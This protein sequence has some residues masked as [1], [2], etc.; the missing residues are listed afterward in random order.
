MQTAH[1]RALALAF[2]LFTL[3]THAVIIADSVNEFSSTQGTHNWFYGFYNQT[4]DASPGYSAADFILFDTF[5]GQAWRASDAQVGA[6]NN[7]F[8]QTNP[9][10][11]HPSGLGPQPQNAVIWAM[12]RY[13]SEAAGPIDIL[14]DLRKVNVTNPRGNG[15]SGRIFVDGVQIYNEVVF[16]TD[17]LAQVQLLTVDVALGSTIDFA[18]DPTGS[19]N[20]DGSG[21]SSA[22]ADGSRLSAVIREAVALPIPSSLALLGL[23]LGLIGMRTH[24]AS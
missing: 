19:G 2:S 21:V 20:A 12:R 11:G 9:I 3:P 13:V 10:G 4:A 17:D 24:R 16:N 8:L 6:N 22:R 15:I 14:F 5:D 18:I 1:V 7:D 23:G